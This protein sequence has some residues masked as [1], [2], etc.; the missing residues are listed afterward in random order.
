[1]S[2][3]PVFP[4]TVFYDGS[5]SV[6]AAVMKRY[7]A[8][9]HGGRLAFVDIS[10][11]DFDPAAFGRTR[12]EFMAR[13]HVLDGRG[14]FYRGVDAFAAIWG[15]LP[16]IGYRMLDRAIRLP[17]IHLL[18]TLGYRLFARNRRYLPGSKKGCADDS[19][20]LGHRR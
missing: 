3:K 9:N 13:M 4:L 1:M 10:A 6:C 17:G 8:K 11:P 19:C 20:S 7:R 2:D 12:E 15:A 14:R 18:A 5:C 16:G